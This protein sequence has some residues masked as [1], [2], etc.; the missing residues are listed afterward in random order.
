MRERYELAE[1]TQGHREGEPYRHRTLRDHFVAAFR[2]SNARRP[3]SFYMLLAI[4]AF[5]LIAAGLP[6][7]RETPRRFAFFLALNF[8]FFYAVLVYA[9]LDFV[10]LGRC[11][12]SER[13]QLFRTTL[14]EDHFVSRLG[15]ANDRARRS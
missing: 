3:G 15:A 2:R 14:G 8:V 7:L 13:R 1:E 9:I 10:A 4:P 11:L 6:V 5:A 12:L